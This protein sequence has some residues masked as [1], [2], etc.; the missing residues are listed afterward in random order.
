MGLA[1]AYQLALEGCRPVLL[2]A[3]D[4]LGGMAAS[5]DFAGVAIER[6]VLTGELEARPR[7]VV[8]LELGKRA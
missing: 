4:R 5:F 1:I 8:K 2:E 7:R 3:D 6:A